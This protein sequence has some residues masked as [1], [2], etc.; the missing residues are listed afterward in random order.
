M[1][2]GLFLLLLHVILFLSY[3]LTNKKHIDS[4]R[5]VEYFLREKF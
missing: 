2:R 3:L 5:F 4:L 1:R